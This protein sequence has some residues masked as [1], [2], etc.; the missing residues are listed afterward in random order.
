LAAYGRPGD[1]FRYYEIN[2]AVVELTA[3]PHPV[4]TYVRDSRARV[5]VVLGDARRRLEDELALGEPGNF[6]VLV[7]DAFSGDS[8]PVHLLTTQAFDTYWKHL[9]PEHGVIAVHITETHIHLLPVMEGLAAHYHCALRGRSVSEGFPF[10]P[11]DWVF[12]S[13]H[14]EALEV[15][16]LF[17]DRPSSARRIPPRL[18]TDDYSDM[19]R[20]LHFLREHLCSTAHLPRSG[21]LFRAAA[22]AHV[23]VTLTVAQDGGL[24]SELSCTESRP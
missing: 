21:I 22:I 6:D 7:L 4:F 5:D 13:R 24:P 20:L 19:V 1:Y 18:W 2:P 11:S 16:G 15:A 17:A 9:N 23:M 8:I 12:L 3:G 14:P 10:A